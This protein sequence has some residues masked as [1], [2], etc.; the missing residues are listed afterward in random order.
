MAALVRRSLIQVA[1][2]KFAI[3][4]RFRA[5]NHHLEQRLVEQ[6][7]HGHQHRRSRD[8]HPRQ[9]EQGRDEDVVEVI[10]ALGVRLHS[11]PGGREVPA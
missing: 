11:Q 7:G 3:F 10:A 6:L 5:R 4:W 8:R 2:P 9:V 1:W